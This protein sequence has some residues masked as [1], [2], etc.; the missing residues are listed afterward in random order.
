MTEDYYLFIH[1]CKDVMF[2]RVTG[3]ILSSSV[4]R[5]YGI[6]VSSVIKSVI[7]SVCCR[8][9]LVGILGFK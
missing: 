5:P 6:C 1:L 8:F 3:F 9:F 2:L 7:I 4:F